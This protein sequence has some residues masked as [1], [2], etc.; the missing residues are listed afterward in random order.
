[1]LR[2]LSH[3]LWKAQSNW[4]T[5]FFGSY[6]L[7]AMQAREGFCSI[8]LLHSFDLHSST[9]HNIFGDYYCSFSACYNFQLPFFIMEGF[10]PD[11]DTTYAMHK[12]NV[13]R[14]LL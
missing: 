4:P 2:G 7:C 12:L 14:S 10:V 8:I 3:L 1:M 5:L 11:F 9:F 13:L 6:T